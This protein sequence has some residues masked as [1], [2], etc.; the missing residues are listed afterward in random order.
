MPTIELPQGA[1]SYRATGPESA[2]RPVVFVHGLLSNG[3]LWDGVAESL[4]AHGVRTY[5]PEWP[6]GSHVIPMKASTDQT[7]RG[8][9]R[10]VIAFLEALGLHDVTLVGNDTGGA[11]CQYVLDT[12]QS[13]I[14]RLVLTNAD[15]FEVFEPPPF[16]IVRVLQ[17]PVLLRTLFIAARLRWLRHL[18][19]GLLVAKPLDPTVSRSWV[20][21]CSRDSGIRRDAIHFMRAIDKHDLLVVSNRMSRFSKPVLLVWG[22]ADRFFT[23]DLARRLRDAFPDAE[24]VEVPGGRTFL[25]LDEPGQVAQ[26][27]LDRF[28]SPAVA[29]R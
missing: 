6:L 9:A 23:L 12:D 19:Y 13:R 10:T 26:E 4:A 27:I 11:L 7:P 29:D 1:I 8:V 15:A 5:T 3:R 22:V 25:P 20:E 14:G 16:N 18:S 2:D 28:Y 24:L 21:P 17:H